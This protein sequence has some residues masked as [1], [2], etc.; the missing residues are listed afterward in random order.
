MASARCDAD[1]VTRNELSAS[2]KGGSQI[3][4]LF[5]KCGIPCATTIASNKKKLT[6]QQEISK[7]ASIPKDDYDPSTFWREHVKYTM[8]LKD[9]LI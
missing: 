8:F 2:L 6:I 3:K 9:K 7:L 1:D 5:N 4:K